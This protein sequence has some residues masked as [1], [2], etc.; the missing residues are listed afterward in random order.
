[1]EYVMDLVNFFSN[2][3]HLWAIA[4]FLGFITAVITIIKIHLSS[5]KFDLVQLFAFD[6][7]TGKLS[8]SKVRLNI[9]FIISCWAFVYLVMDGK[10]TEWYFFGFM[11]AWVTDRIFSRKATPVTESTDPE[12]K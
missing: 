1:M 5:H 8:D 11:G 9:A 6:Q 4:S 7:Q 12:T 2:P 3:K 10:F